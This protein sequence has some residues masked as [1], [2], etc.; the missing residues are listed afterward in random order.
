MIAQDLILD[1]HFGSPCREVYFGGLTEMRNQK[2]EF[3]AAEGA[4]FNVNRVPERSEVHR[5][6]AQTIIIAVSLILWMITKSTYTSKILV[7]QSMGLLANQKFQCYHST[8]KCRNLTS[9]PWHS[10]ETSEKVCIMNRTSLA[11]ERGPH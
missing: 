1:V 2:S 9:Q 8:R 10:V 6:R 5:E 11:L 3:V 4:Y 7:K